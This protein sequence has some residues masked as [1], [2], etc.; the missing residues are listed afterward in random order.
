MYR[1]AAFLKDHVSPVLEP[2]GW[3]RDG[4]DFFLTSARE[5]V[6]SID[7]QRST[8]S[9]DGEVYFYIN[10]AAVPK[11]YLDFVIAMKARPGERV[12]PNSLIG[13]HPERFMVRLNPPRG[14]GQPSGN[15]WYDG[16]APETINACVSA[17]ADPLRSTA[18]DLAKFLDRNQLLS[19]LK[20]WRRPDDQLL[21]FM[22]TMFAADDGRLD[23]ARELAPTIDHES[24][25]SFALSRVA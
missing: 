22:R 20:A 9:H 16:S 1:L 10:L 3:H 6:V 17:L 19:A 12:K 23:E 25:R 21:M 18:A 7:F 14:A 13:F 8:S 24:L 5:D 11:P 2:L 15:W 4:V